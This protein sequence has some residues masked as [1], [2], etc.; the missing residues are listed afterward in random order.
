MN[1]KK[2]N[3]PDCMG[4]YNTIYIGSPED[5]KCLF[6]CFRRQYTKGKSDIEP[7]CYADYE[8][9]N[10]KYV[11]ASDRPDFPI[12]NPW[13][14]VYGLVVERWQFRIINQ[15]KVASMMFDLMPRESTFEDEEE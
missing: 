11:K 9:K 13:R 7:A 15:D 4:Y 6:K 14:S 2:I 5:I 1:I 10:G 8:I 12:L 3:I